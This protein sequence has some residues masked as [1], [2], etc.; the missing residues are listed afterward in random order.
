MDER[1]ENALKFANYMTLFESQKRILKEKYQ[2]NLLFFYNGSQFTV[3]QQLISFLASLKTLN[4]DEIVL[5]DDNELPVLIEDLEDFT[6]K[7]LNV[8]FY[9]TNSYLGEYNKLKKNRTVEG[10]ILD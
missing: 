4:Q 7:I 6:S 1:L 9:A 10:I 5:V 3:S 8:Y 2:N